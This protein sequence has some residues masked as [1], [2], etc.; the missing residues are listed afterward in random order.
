MQD[1]IL[2]LVSFAIGT[3]ITWFITKWFY[4]RAA[5]DLKSETLKIRRLLDIVLYALEK[6][7]MVKVNRDASGQVI[8]MEFEL[9]VNSAVHSMTS[10]N[11]TLNVVKENQNSK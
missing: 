11:V 3:I 9:F 10:D 1:W 6:A 7:K 4:K 2:N 5:L 8:G